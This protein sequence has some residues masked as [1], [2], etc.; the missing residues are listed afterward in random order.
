MSASAP[1][2]RAA[3][4]LVEFQNQWT[5]PGPYHRLIRDQLTSRSVVA[6]TRGDVER[7]A[8]AA[9]R[10]ALGGRVITHEKLLSAITAAPV[11]EYGG[12]AAAES[13]SAG[14]P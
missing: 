4:L 5:L 12:A 8:S 11:R 6:N 7:V 9:R 13:S 2:D 14:A 3:V 1:A 10:E